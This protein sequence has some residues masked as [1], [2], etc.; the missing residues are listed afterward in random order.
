MTAFGECP[1][2][3]NELT[4]ADA[5]DNYP[6]GLCMGCALTLATVPDDEVEAHIAKWNPV[7]RTIK[8]GIE[9]ERRRKEWN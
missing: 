5:E 9:D 1:F 8:Q 4:K 3:G 6:H 7:V 2:C